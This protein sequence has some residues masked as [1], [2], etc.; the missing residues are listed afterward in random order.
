MYIIWF[1]PQGS[2]FWKLILTSCAIKIHRPYGKIDNS[3]FRNDFNYSKI[4]TSLHARFKRK[5]QT[6]YKIPIV[7]L[8][9]IGPRTPPPLKLQ[10]QVS[11][12]TPPNDTF[13]RSAHAITTVILYLM[14]ARNYLSAPLIS[15]TYGILK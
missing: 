6:Y 11:I 5:T 2:N 3:H 14:D 1:T 10:T 15:L 9:K 8:L 7:K 12:E 13:S 4:K